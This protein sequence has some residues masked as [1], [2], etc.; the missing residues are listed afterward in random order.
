M[1]AFGLHVQHAW[2]TGKPSTSEVV[3]FKRSVALHRGFPLVCHLCVLRHIP[4]VTY[5][6]GSVA[7]YHCVY[8]MHIYILSLD[9]CIRYRYICMCAPTW[10][11]MEKSHY[12]LNVTREN[13]KPGLWPGRGD[14]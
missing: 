8:G 12:F 10:K 4:R 6:C 11:P 9:M 1:P 13:Y 5:T 7:V 14:R 3:S 2:H